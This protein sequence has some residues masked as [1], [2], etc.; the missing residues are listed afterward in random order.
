MSELDWIAPSLLALTFMVERL[1]P[2]MSDR[3]NKRR[4]RIE[5]ARRGK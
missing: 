3:A 5:R 2:L 1:L 4:V